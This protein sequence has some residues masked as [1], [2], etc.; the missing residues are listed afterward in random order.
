[1]VDERVVE[2]AWMPRGSFYEQRWAWIKWKEAWE[3]STR[4]VAC[5]Q[6]RVIWPDSYKSTTP[7]TKRKCSVTTRHNVGEKNMNVMV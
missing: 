3:R 5:Y 1:M 2:H 6:Q 4:R 7:A